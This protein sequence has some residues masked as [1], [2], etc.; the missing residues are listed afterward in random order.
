VDGILT[1]W[2]ADAL[3]SF[4]PDPK[5][6]RDGDAEYFE[7]L[8]VDRIPF[9]FHTTGQAVW[10]ATRLL[11]KS[12]CRHSHN[13]DADSTL[14]VKFR[15]PG[16]CDSDQPSNLL[17]RMVLR[18]YVDAGRSIILWRAQTKGEGRLTDLQAD[19]TGWSVVGPADAVTKQSIGMP[20]A[21]LNFMRFT[22]SSSTGA[23]VDH[24]T[25][26]G[27]QFVLLAEVSGNDD[28]LEI[29]RLMES[30]LLDDSRTH[31]SQ[32]VS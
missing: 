1:S 2:G 19:E 20:T 10:Q 6:L 21:M 25:G 18:R 12:R 3:A 14:A 4:F 23:A 7:S 8:S 31:C 24:K 17:I 11:H 9:D 30:L 5:I 16:P 29:V 22:P 27:A 26:K 28:G 13:Y 15:V 32:R